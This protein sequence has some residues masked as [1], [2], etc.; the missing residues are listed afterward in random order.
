MPAPHG[1]RMTSATTVSAPNNPGY[2]SQCR[3]GIVGARCVVAAGLGLGRT[4]GRRVAVAGAREPI[5]GVGPGVRVGVGR[6]TV[7]SGVQRLRFPGD[8]IARRR[9]RRGRAGRRGVRRRGDGP[10]RL[11][12]GTGDVR[13][14]GFTP[15]IS[16]L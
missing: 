14:Y 12:G 8:R 6:R 9:F 2:R 13:H 1:T 7:H 3:R 5:G 11:V 15:V 4:R 16:T 10:G